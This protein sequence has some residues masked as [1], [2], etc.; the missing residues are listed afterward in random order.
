MTVF[1][2][3]HEV[4]ICPVLTTFG[5][6]MGYALATRRTYAYMPLQTFQNSWCAYS[7]SAIQL[8]YM[9]VRAMQAL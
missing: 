1:L 6:S 4:Y 3:G 2:G 5:M 7:T 9:V 8:V